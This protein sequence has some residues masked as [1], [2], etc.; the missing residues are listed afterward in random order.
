MLFP[1]YEIKLN[2]PKFPVEEFIVGPSPHQELAGNSLEKFL[3]SKGIG[4]RIHGPP[5]VFYDRR[6][7]LQKD[8]ITW[9][10]ANGPAV[11]LSEVPYRQL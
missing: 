7:V 2:T 6:D 5:Q 8:P 4:L 10:V 9:A 3:V 1:Y 11:K